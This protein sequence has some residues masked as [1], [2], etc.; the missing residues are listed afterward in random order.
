M[1]PKA[2][3]IPM[4]ILLLQPLKYWNFY[5]DESQCVRVCVRVC[6]KERDYEQGHLS[7]F[8]YDHSSPLVL[9]LTQERR[10]K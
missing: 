1:L 7:L 5:R 8:T 2:D 10:K 4:A 6:V 3:L 9:V